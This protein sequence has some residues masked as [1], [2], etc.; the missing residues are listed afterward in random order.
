MKACMG[1]AAAAAGKTMKTATRTEKAGWK[2]QCVADAKAEFEAA[3]GDADDWDVSK[4]KGAKSRGAD[5]MKS[6]VE[7]AA[8]AA[9]KTMKDAT[10]TEKAGGKTQCEADAK[11]E[12]E[13]AGGA[14]DDWELQRE[15]GAR[16]K[17]ADKMK[18]CMDAAAAAAGKT[19][20]TATRTEKAGWKRQC[21]ADAKAE[22]EA[23]GGEADDW[24]LAR[25]EGARSNGANQMKA[26]VGAAAT[27]AGKTMKTATRTE[28]EGWIATCKADAAADFEASGGKPE[29]W[30]VAQE[31][32]AAASGGE[33]L[34][35]C[36]AAAAE[37]SGKAA[38]DV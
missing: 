10:R 27:A 13:A 20:K 28:K 11:A 35:V 25:L 31:E 38:K 4:R 1:A 14:A 34:M 36:I 33:K 30:P 5:K 24:E 29:H 18:A 23:A 16:A 7:A 3:G 19:I 9:G 2:T 26:C 12:F 17:G 6:C 22:F 15:H 8:T 37:G 21:I 32:G